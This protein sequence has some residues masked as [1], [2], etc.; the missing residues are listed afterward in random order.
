MYRMMFGS[1]ENRPRKWIYNERWRFLVVLVVPTQHI[2]SSYST[3]SLTLSL[4][5]SL[6]NSFL[7]LPSF[8]I[9]FL[10]KCWITFYPFSMLSFNVDSKKH[11]IFFHN[12]TDFS[13]TA[14][15]LSLPPHCPLSFCLIYLG[16]TCAKV[17]SSI[18]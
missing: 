7:L 14:F 15:F 2:S 16:S 5:Y 3:L 18:V 8:F 10:F 11:S 17:K 4:T 12:R 13:L 1:K 9:F 6:Y